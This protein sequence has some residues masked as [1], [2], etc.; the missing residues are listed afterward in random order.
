M[1]ENV[2]S[3]DR[4]FAILELL[5]DFPD[6]VGV[7]EIGKRLTLHKST[8]HRLLLTLINNGYVKQNHLTSNYE[9][10][11][12]LFEIGNK[13]V[14]SIDIVSIAQPYLKELME[15]T[16]EV[17]HL[18]VRENA[19]IVYLAKVEAPRSIKVY[20][21]VGM[22][23]P[24]YCTAMGKAI[25]SYMPNDEVQEI[26]DNSNIIKMTEYTITTIKNFK[27]VLEISKASGYALDDQE[28][29]LGIKCIG[30]A[31]RD[32]KGLVCGAIS[33]SCSTFSLT[34][35]NEQRYVELIISY[36]AKI[37][38]ELGYKG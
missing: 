32:Y 3:I 10:T 36:A 2:Q 30:V 21:R 5:A 28:V 9:L 18:G 6:G 37:S 29:E 17:V 8:A 11:L 13:K 33:L 25:L 31:I 1:Q 19:E 22:R 14:E 15:L 4:C 38:A 7:T 24:M 27:K 20:S 23:K 35:E 34:T 16:N 12:K 26:W